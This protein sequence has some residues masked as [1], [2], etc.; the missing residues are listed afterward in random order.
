MGGF[1]RG[2]KGEQGSPLVFGGHCRTVVHWVE[3]GAASTEAA[4]RQT[5]WVD[6]AVSCTGLLP[7][8]PVVWSWDFLSQKCVSSHILSQWIFN[9]RCKWQPSNYQVLLRHMR[10]RSWFP[11][12]AGIS[13]GSTPV[14]TASQPKTSGL[15]LKA[16]AQSPAY[17]AGGFWSLRNWKQKSPSQ[18]EKLV[19][20]SVGSC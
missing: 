1:E 19:W 7:L 14:S 4:L 12:R 15:R 5:W 2:L 9:S 17:G 3:S 6:R 20:A 11:G 16:P 8:P 13:T 18:L 10:I